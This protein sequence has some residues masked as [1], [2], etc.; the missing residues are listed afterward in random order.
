MDVVGRIRAG[1]VVRP[2]EVGGKRY[3][4]F[5]VK[6]VFVLVERVVVVAR[7][8]GL[9]VAEKQ[10]DDRSV[11]FFEALLSCRSVRFS[12]TVLSWKVVLFFEGLLLE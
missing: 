12:G 8:R 7:K 5:V 3:A 2:D 6:L 11:R 10:N 4:R 9:V 1:V